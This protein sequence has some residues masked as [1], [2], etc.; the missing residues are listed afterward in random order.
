MVP[1]GGPDLQR[2]Q[3]FSR[4]YWGT[5]GISTDQKGFRWK[6]RR[7]WNFLPLF[8]LWY[9]PKPRDALGAFRKMSKGWQN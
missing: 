9:L 5:D 4:L 6:W 8:T 2:S 3:E 1:Q 7:K